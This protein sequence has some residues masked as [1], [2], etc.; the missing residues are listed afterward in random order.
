M[1]PIF[2]YPHACV[3]GGGE[4]LTL[5]REEHGRQKKNT[6]TWAKWRPPSDGRSM[7]GDLPSVG[8][9]EWKDL[10]DKLKEVSMRI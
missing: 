8:M 3:I 2:T 4:V 6:Y 1:P 9:G 5:R 10:N 7:G